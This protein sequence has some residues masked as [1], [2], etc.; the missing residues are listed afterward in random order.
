MKDTDY[1]LNTFAFTEHNAVWEHIMYIV[2]LNIQAEV[3]QAISPIK[4]GEARIHQ[5]GRASAIT[6]FKNLLLEERKK[7]RVNAGLTPE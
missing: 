6:D 3:E 2:D 7:A 4:Q 5:C 1:N